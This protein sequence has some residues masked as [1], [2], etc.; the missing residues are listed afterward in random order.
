MKLNTKQGLPAKA[1]DASSWWNDCMIHDMLCSAW[2]LAL[3]CRNKDV[4]EYWFSLFLTKSWR[5]D[6][7]TDGPTD[8]RTDWP[9]YRDARTHLKS[10]STYFHWRLE[11]EHIFYIQ[12]RQIHFKIGPPNHLLVCYRTEARSWRMKQLLKEGKIQSRGIL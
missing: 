7:R 8:G 4:Q 3:I 2:L 1:N 6:R 5:K 10:I 11:Q 9:I 12:N